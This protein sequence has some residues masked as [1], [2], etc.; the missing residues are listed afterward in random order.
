MPDGR[1][2]PAAGFV[3]GKYYVVGGWGA[4]A[5]AAKKTLIYDPATNLWSGG[6]DN[7]KPW[8]AVGSA[9]LDG[10]LYSIGGCT[11]DCQTATSDVMV[12]DPATN[13]FSQAA[14]YPEPVSWTV[15]RWL[16]TAASYCAGG[17]VDGPA[18]RP[19]ST[20]STYAYDAKANTWTRVADL[21]VDL[22]ASSSRRG[23]RQPDGQR[24]RG[25]RLVGR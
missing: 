15:L 9:V 13:R 17:L 23:E 4:Q 2:R 10:K 20:K 6:A 5:G 16:S 3:D 24:R 25:V 12:Y 22:W 8:G 11:G 14:S 21:P 18:G 7:P 1:Q 19:L